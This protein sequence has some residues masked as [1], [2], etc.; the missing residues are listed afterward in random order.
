MHFS[1]LL[2]GLFAAGAVAAPA[3]D[4]AV[5]QIGGSTSNELEDGSCKPVIF[6]NARASTEPGNM[7]L[8][9][10]PA[11]C[12]SLKRAL[13]DVACQGVGGAYSAGLAQNALPG[14]SSQGAFDEAKR[15]FNLAHTKCPDSTIVAS[16]YSQGTAVMNGAIKDLDAEVQD[17]IAGVVLFGYTKNAQNDGEIENFP[18]DKVKVYCAATDGVCGGA[19]LVTAGHFTYTDDV[20]PASDFLQQK[21]QSAGSSSSSS[22]SSSSGEE[23]SSSGSGFGSLFG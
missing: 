4:L 18:A 23:S 5:R 12:S 6:I 21:V 10:G 9:T 16:G 17:Q 7:G 13:G 3:K 20:S 8:S 22:S 11:L 2:T 19:L 1:P 14:G 15:L